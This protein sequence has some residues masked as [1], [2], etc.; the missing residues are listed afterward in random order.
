VLSAAHRMT[1]CSK[2]YED[3]PDYQHHDSNA[4]EDRDFCNESNQQKDNTEDN[5]GWSPL[6]GVMLNTAFT[7]GPS[8][9]NYGNRHLLLAGLNESS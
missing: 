3:E 2:D 8:G 7:R 9:T 5:H 4:P 1:H 6:F